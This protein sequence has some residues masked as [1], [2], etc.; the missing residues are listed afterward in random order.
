VSERKRE[1]GS[2]REN[3]VQMDSG[4][5]ILL[6]PARSFMNAN[7]HEARKQKKRALVRA[8]NR[9]KKKEKERERERE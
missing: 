2:G 8:K 6:A 7:E 4:G 1:K 5:N 9:K 3:E